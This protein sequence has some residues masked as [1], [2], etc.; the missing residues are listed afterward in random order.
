[1]YHNKLFPYLHEL[2][3]ETQQREV[4]ERSSGPGAQSSAEKL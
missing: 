2:K 3:H 1:M 4:I